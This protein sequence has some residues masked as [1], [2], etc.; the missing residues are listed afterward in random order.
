MAE[1]S[2]SALILIT[3]WTVD[4]Q[5]INTQFHQGRKL[6]LSSSIAVEA[7]TIFLDMNLLIKFHLHLVH[8]SLFK[9]WGYLFWLLVFYLK[10]KK[11]NQ[12]GR[13]LRDYSLLISPGRQWNKPGVWVKGGLVLN[14]RPRMYGII[15]NKFLNIYLYIC[16]LNVYIIYIHICKSR[17]K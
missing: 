12:H 3:L 13:C 17:N 1:V 11:E 2:W 7:L 10:K 6:I 9:I 16:Y 5:S 8:T 4:R 15:P 14:H